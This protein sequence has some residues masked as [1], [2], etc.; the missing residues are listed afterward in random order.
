[1]IY[2]VTRFD[3]SAPGMEP[4]RDQDE[5]ILIAYLGEDMAPLEILAQWQEDIDS[6]ARPDGFDY[7][8]ARAAIDRWAGHNLER[9]RGE[10]E[11]FRDAAKRGDFSWNDEDLE[12][13]FRLYVRDTRGED[14]E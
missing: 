7:L 9:I 2:E 4:L 8:E 3:N 6:C 14:Q 5:F 11:F 13:P 10:I 12:I 1:M